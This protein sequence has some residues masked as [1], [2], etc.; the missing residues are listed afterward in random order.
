MA[1]KLAEAN[2]LIRFYF[3]NGSEWSGF[4]ARC[5]KCRHFIDDPENPKPGKVTPPHN[6]CAW[7]VLDRIY[8]SMATGRY[9]YG[10]SYH[11]PEDAEVVRLNPACKRFT[12]KDDENGEFRDPPKPDCPGQLVLGESDVPVEKSPSACKAV[13]T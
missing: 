8:E 11:P 5:D 4:E 1:C 9:G 2:G 12:H 6:C 10:T 13:G 3:A 7:G